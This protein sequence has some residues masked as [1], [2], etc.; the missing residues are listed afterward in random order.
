M[1]RVEELR[2]LAR[3]A[4]AKSLTSSDPVQRSQWM[5]IAA[6]WEFLANTRQKFLESGLLKAGPPDEPH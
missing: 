5:E 3:E 6:N 1:E 2:R 4:A